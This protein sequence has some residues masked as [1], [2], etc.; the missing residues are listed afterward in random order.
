VKI[1]CRKRKKGEA[2]DF[3]ASIEK[4]KGEK[5]PANSSPFFSARER[6]G[7]AATKEGESGGEGSS[8]MKGK[9]GESLQSQQKT[10]QN[11]P[12]GGGV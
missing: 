1:R 5:K 7:K 2:K 4:K 10:K 6:K 12:R 11:C 9:R 3:S 8:A